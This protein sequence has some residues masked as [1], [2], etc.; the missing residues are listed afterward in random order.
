MAIASSWRDRG[1]VRCAVVAAVAV[2]FVSLGV[3]TYEIGGVVGVLSPQSHIA[4]GTGG[5]A[6]FRVARRAH[7][8]G[9]VLL[10]RIGGAGCSALAANVTLVRMEDGVAHTVARQSARNG[11]FRFLVAPGNYI[12]TAEI[13]GARAVRVRCL[14]SRVVV[15]AGEYVRADVR[16]HPRPGVK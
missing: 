11:H 15:R 5:V 8:S 13:V 3:A 14:T 6:G 4:A 9:E 1:R 12:P 7:L 10:C 16:C 2:V